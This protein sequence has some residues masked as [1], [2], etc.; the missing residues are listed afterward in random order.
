M[1]HIYSRWPQFFVTNGPLG[2]FFSEAG[3]NTVYNKSIASSDSFLQTQHMFSSEI[4]DN[5]SL[6]L[7]EISGAEVMNW[8][9]VVGLQQIFLMFWLF[10][11]L[12]LVFCLLF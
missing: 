10:L 11:C 9:P 4:L 5:V 1:A 12:F 2:P 3:Q 7:S 8:W 6:S